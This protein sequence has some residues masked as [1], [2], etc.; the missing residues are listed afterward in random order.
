MVCKEEDNIYK[1]TL[2]IVTSFQ[3][4]FSIGRLRT[5]EKVVDE[6][7]TERAYISSAMKCTWTLE[8]DLAFV[9]SRVPPKCFGEPNYV[10]GFMAVHTLCLLQ[11]SIK[12]IAICL[13]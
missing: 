12:S 8:S 3:H 6:S 13:G 9:W 2:L 7:N 10:V 1:E 5:L 4:T 11:T